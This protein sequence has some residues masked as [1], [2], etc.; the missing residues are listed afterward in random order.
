MRQELTIEAKLTD[1]CN[2]HCRHCM[3]HD[4]PEGRLELDV[5]LFVGRLEEFAASKCKDFV[6]K[7]VRLTGGEPTLLPNAICRLALACGKLGIEC[8]INTNAMLLTGPMAAGLK[9]A[10]LSLVK[11]SLDSTD[12]QVLSHFRG[13]P[14]SAAR[15]LQ[16]VDNA[17][18]A[19]LEIIIRFTLSRVTREQ[20]LPCYLAAC[21]RGI[22]LFQIKPL[23]RSGRGLETDDALNPRE[24]D[25]ALA[26]LRQA[27]RQGRTQIRV[28]C[29]PTHYSGGLDTKTCGS[30]DKVYVSTSGDV[31]ICNYV[32]NGKNLG[33]IRN[34]SLETIF[35]RRQGE[36]EQTPQG[37]R[38]VAKCSQREF[39][40]LA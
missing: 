33:N 39:F 35:L 36:F 26:K 31:C 9:K 27:T 34:E 13:T 12:D 8:G 29:W 40:C 10:G 28:L 6:V 30:V 3:N 2:Q 16:G 23:I 38:M 24:I 17:K 5:D 32:Y 11:I 19:G 20:L 18:A 15:T 1:R 7:S 22:E 37:D 21:D 25:K 14:A 4:S